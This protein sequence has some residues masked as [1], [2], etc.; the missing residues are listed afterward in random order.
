[1]AMVKRT[2]TPHSAAVQHG[3]CSAHWAAAVMLVVV[4]LDAHV[5][6]S[7]FLGGLLLSVCM[8]GCV[9]RCCR[10]PR[11]RSPTNVGA[12]RSALWL[13]LFISPEVMVSCRRGS[14]PL[15]K[16]PL[17]PKW[18][19]FPRLHLCAAA[20]ISS[21]LTPSTCRLINTA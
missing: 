2:M 7:F 15:Q 21:R 12:Y 20:H 19:E 17:Y 10:K 8:V 4:F 3:H 16:K 6:P 14:G 18:T 9:Q 13:L 11:R 5:T 1:M